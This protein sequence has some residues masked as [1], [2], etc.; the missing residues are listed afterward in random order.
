M[1][2]WDVMCCLLSAQLNR[3]HTTCQ[4]VSLPHVPMMACMPKWDHASLACV[5]ALATSRLQQQKTLSCDGILTHYVVV[6]QSTDDVGAGGA[7]VGGSA[8][9]GNVNGYKNLGSLGGN[10]AGGTGVDNSKNGRHLLKYGYNKQVCHPH[11][12]LMQDC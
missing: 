12:V 8:A 1:W 7:G 3:S 6:V 10:G 5:G 4:M 2:I 11:G 9:T